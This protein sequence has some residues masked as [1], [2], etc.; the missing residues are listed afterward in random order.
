VHGLFIGKEQ[1]LKDRKLKLDG[2]SNFLHLM[3][4]MDCRYWDSLEISRS[5]TFLFFFCWC[6]NGNSIGLSK[7][8]WEIIELSKYHML[9]VP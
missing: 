4:I 7:Y 8:C 3:A 1:L 5:F 9:G 2:G 6:Q